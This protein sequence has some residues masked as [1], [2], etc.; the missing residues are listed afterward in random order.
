EERVPDVVDRIERIAD[1]EAVVVREASRELGVE[2][3]VAHDPRGRD[4]AGEP[5]AED[6]QDQ[7]E[8]GQGSRENGRP[9]S[10]APDVLEARFASLDR[11]DRLLHQGILG[12]SSAGP[13]AQDRRRNPRM[14][15]RNEGKKTWIPT[16]ITEAASTASLA[17]E[18]WPKP[19]CTH[20][21]MRTPPSVRPMAIRTAPANRPC[22]SRTRARR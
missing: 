8:A 19:L 12:S 1:E 21:A 6:D 20:R 4:L 2:K 14:L 17:S 16:I 11:V 13:R 9:A 5:D 15:S 10:P 7:D 18:S 22:S 3:L